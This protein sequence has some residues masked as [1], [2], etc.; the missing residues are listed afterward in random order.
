MLAAMFV[1][2]S[3]A[4]SA[5]LLVVTIAI[6]LAAGG[7]AEPSA[8]VHVIVTMKDGDFDDGHAFDHLTLT[9]N[10]GD[11][12]AAA[13]LYPADAVNGAVPLDDPSP[14]A[15]ADRRAQPWT[16]PP[17]AASWALASAPRTINVDAI[18]GEE[19]EVTVTG[20][21][22]GRL[23]TVRGEGKLVASPS[24]PDLTIELKP[25]QPLFPDGCGARL[26][27]SFPAE[28]DA[29][30]GI[31]DATLDECP[32]T[33]GLLTRSPAVAC[34]EDGTSRI[35][36]G[37][38]VTCSV[39]QGE[40]IVWRTPPLPTLYSCVRIFVRGQL[41][42]C[43]KGDPGDLSGCEETTACAPKP[44]TVWSR[45]KGSDTFFSEI[46]LDCLPP[47]VVP[48]TWSVLLDLPEQAAFVGLS[49]STRTSDDGACF[50][51][52]EAIAS[53]SKECIP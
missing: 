53:T 28:F 42:R 5:P 16:G 33:A 17:S 37:P 32:A 34:L 21:L 41:A 4:V 50:L 18:E 27:P 49:Q 15:C 52:V 9:A 2:R 19:I 30:Y 45:T 24:W 38:G 7:C 36:N 35:R 6:A 29:K 40:P 13:C 26:D 23:G 25:A 8:G 11:R 3:L 22:G 1:R 10:V 43:K 48:I 20:G 31:C 47:T 12:S 51:D 39:E 14:N 46:A 44:V